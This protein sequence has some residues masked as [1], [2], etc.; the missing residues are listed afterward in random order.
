V[1]TWSGALILAASLALM[2]LLQFLP[3]TLLFFVGLALA[4]LLK[5]T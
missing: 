1:G 3:G 5:P 4:P 2:S